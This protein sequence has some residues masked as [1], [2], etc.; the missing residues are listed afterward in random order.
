[1]SKFKRTAEQITK[2]IAEEEFAPVERTAIEWDN[3][4]VLSTRSTNLD[5]AISGGRLEEGGIPACIL[6]MIHGPSGSGKTSILSELA[7]DAQQKGGDTHNQDPEARLDKEYAR[8]YDMILNKENYSRPGRVEEV[9]AFI[10]TWETQKK[11]KAL[12]T[13]SLAALTTDLEIETGDSMGMRR[14]KMFSQGCRKNARILGDMLWVCS[15]QE[16]QNK[17]GGFTV[18][19]GDAIAFYSSLIIRAKM[20]DTVKVKKK[21][22]YGVE[23][24]KIIGIK[25]ECEVRKSTI[26][27]P[28]RK[29]IIFI[30]FGL[31]IDDVRGNLQYLKEMQKLTTYPCPDGKNYMGLEQAI[32]HVEEKGMQKELKKQTIAMWNE[33]ESLFKTNRERT[34]IR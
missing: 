7:G 30:I 11:P 31:G 34:R 22:E 32:T 14:A 4:P 27:D 33:C 26:D 6:A 1:M 2:T 17:N 5:L 23:L 9:F 16:R 25:T 21:N 3:I 8:I 24:E 18:P 28:F 15:N 13:D 12:F 19:G 10:E 20:I 29:A